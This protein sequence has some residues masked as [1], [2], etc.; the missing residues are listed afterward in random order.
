MY[1]CIVCEQN[2]CIIS[3]IIYLAYEQKFAQK[4]LFFFLEESCHVL[5]LTGYNESIL[6]V[7][8]LS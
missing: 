1:Y 8:K 5:Y 2:V 4:K 6:I 7:T 3:Y